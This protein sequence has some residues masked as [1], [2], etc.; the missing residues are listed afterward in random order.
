MLGRTLETALEPHNGAAPAAV[1][2]S[3][4]ARPLL[5]ARGLAR[6]GALEHVDLDIRPG[7]AVGL[8][9]LL[10]SGRSETARALFGADPLDAGD[11]E[12]DASPSRPRS[13]RHAC[14]LGLALTTEN[15]RADGIIPH[16]SVRENIA[17]ALQA[18]RGLA[19]PIPRREQLRLADRFI[20]ALRIKTP[21]PETP[22]ANLSGGN[23]Q[24]ALLARWLATEPRLL[25]LDEPTRG[26]DVGAKAEI[27][28]LIDE[29]RAKGMS[30]LVI[31]SEL[32]EVLHACQRVVVM[33]DRRSVARLDA[34]DCTMERVLRAIAG[35]APLPNAPENAHGA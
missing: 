25:M 28:R 17:L 20:A 4:D 30:L 23:Q 16:L 24:K 7:E 26:I 2:A 14:R 11:I 32:E 19:R 21:S 27:L 15:R 18:R 1:G 31:S 6:R 5:R 8:A 3:S 9:G 13:P 12:I 29:L 34:G 22:I 35:D 33:R 10:G